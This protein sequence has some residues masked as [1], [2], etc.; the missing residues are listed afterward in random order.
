ML[1]LYIKFYAQRQ[2]L[3]SGIIGKKM[4]H[5]RQHLQPN[6]WIN[7]YWS[8]WSHWSQTRSILYVVCIASLCWLP[9]IQQDTC[10]SNNSMHHDVNLSHNKTMKGTDFSNL[11][12]CQSVLLEKINHA[13]L[14]THMWKNAIL[15]D[16]HTWPS[17]ENGWLLENGHYTIK[18]FSGQQVP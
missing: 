2:T 12:P 10:S 18:W 3:P 5:G 15:K 13:N 16:S 1:W 4:R 6:M 8:H 14:V 7:W 11:P 9:W 17:E